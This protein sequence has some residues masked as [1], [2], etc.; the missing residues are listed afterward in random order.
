MAQR[1]VDGWAGAR[2]VGRVLDENVRGRIIAAHTASRG[3]V[4]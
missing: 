1:K 4:G 2:P 3:Y